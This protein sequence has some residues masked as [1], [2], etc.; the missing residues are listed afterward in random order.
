MPKMF[1][2]KPT[3][4]KFWDNDMEEW[5]GGIA[6]NDV[7]ICGCCGALFEIK[8]ILSEAPDTV[9]VPIIDLPWVAI[10]EEILGQ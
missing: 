2:E 9:A 3:Q 1:Y 6:F 10:D 8:E 4:V 5:I 7:I